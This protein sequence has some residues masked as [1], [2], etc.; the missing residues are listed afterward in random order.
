MVGDMNHQIFRAKLPYNC[1]VLAV[2][3]YNIHE[4]KLSISESANL[5]VYECN[6]F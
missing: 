1:Q 2:L 6:I 3:F 5:T 4:V